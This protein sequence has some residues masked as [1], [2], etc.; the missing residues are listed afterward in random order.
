MFLNLIMCL[1]PNEFL[2]IFTFIASPIAALLALEC[3]LEYCLSGLAVGVTEHPPS[4][5]R[6][7]AGAAGERVLPGQEGTGGADKGGAED[8]SQG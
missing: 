6:V 3:D 4:V 8:I 7:K 1:L 5:A 2:D